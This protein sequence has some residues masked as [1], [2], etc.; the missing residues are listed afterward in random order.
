MTLTSFIG[1][2]GMLAAAFALHVRVQLLSG[3]AEGWPEAPKAVRWAM[4]T[5]IIPTALAGLW[6]VFSGRLPEWLMAAVAV[7]WAAY[8]GAMAVN[9]GRQRGST[10]AAPEAGK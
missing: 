2:G 1:G 10:T 7:S 8:S 9:I 3:H 6:W 5:A 4:D